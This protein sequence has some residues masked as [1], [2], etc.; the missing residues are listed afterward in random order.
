MFEITPH[1][2]HRHSDSSIS[3]LYDTL[4][5]KQRRLKEKQHLTW[6]ATEISAEEPRKFHNAVTF[7]CFF[8][9]IVKI[10]DLNPLIQV[11]ASA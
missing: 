11:Y 10:L 9:R 4:V 8:K 2:V 7:V 5:I 6:N 1:Y 3:G